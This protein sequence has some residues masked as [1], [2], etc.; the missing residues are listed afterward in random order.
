MPEVEAPGEFKT[1]SHFVGPDAAFLINK[2]Q[3]AFS[4]TEF[5]GLP[6]SPQRFGLFT[7]HP[8]ALTVG[9]PS[10]QGGDFTSAC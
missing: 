8:P 7:R 9:Y 2:D 1:D 4:M 5:Q 6:Y 10:R 3:S